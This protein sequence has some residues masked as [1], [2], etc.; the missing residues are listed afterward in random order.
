MPIPPSCLELLREMVRIES[1][2]ATI[3]GR[4]A[5]E[6]EL[7]AYM[8]RVAAGWGLATQ[9][10]SVGE[11]SFNLLVWREANPAAPWLLMES[12]LDTVGV[13]GMIGDPFGGRVEQGRLYGRGACDTKGSGAAM[14]W[15]LRR[16]AAEGSGPN[17]VAIVYTVDEEAHKAGVDAF[18]EQH[19][20]ALGWRVRGA[21]VGEPTMLRPV[22]ASNGVV[23]WAIR[24]HGIAAHSSDPTRG[25]SAIR[26][27][28]RV[29]DA[30]ETRYIARLS[31]AHPLTGP[32]RCSINRIRGG[33][34]INIIPEECEIWIDR[35]VV[36]G[37]NPEEVLPEVRRVMEELRGEVPD[38]AYSMTEPFMDWPLDPAGG[39]AF[40]PVVQG[41]LQD[42]GLST[43][44]T[45]VGY[46]SDGSTLRAAGMLV[47]ILGP[48]DIAQ[49]HAAEEYLE[50]DQLERAVDVYGRLMRAPL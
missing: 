33:S 32:A 27:M 3:S 45:G 35:R 37:E 23:R 42:A 25:R 17:N 2:N 26:L 47:V 49:A 24:T 50:L 14:L 5:P 7:G 8:E 12:H 11:D 16:Y 31:A 41:V 15:A 29:I 9:R 19:L 34:V 18:V 28:M 43:E 38:L 48:G 36:P 40:F 13:E 30:L 22:V 39:E 44:L 6:A 46:G 10:L 1:I 4:V 21:I 20:P